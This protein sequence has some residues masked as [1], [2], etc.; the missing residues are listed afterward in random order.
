MTIYEL[1]RRS[2]GFARKRDRE[3]VQVAKIQYAIFKGQLKKVPKIWELAGVEKPKSDV[4]MSKE[5]VEKD[6]ARKLK[7]RSD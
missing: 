6:I 5:E 4:N 1:N 7:A 3:N 2:E